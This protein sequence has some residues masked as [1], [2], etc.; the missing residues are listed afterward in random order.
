MSQTELKPHPI[1]V[2][3]N[4]PITD[5]LKS[6]KV[7]RGECATLWQRQRDKKKWAERDAYKGWKEERH[8]EVCQTPFMPTQP[9]QYACKDPL[10]KRKI[11][12]GRRQRERLGLTTP[13]R[14]APWGVV[15][16][17]YWSHPMECP[18]ESGYLDTLPHGV[19]SWSDPIMGAWDGWQADGVWVCVEERERRIAA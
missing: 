10:C 12:D 8:C 17:S 14:E 13:R 7:H 18:W 19:K 6:S 9:H 16:P 15:E 3:C 5:Q 4:K 2:I 1:C 11:K